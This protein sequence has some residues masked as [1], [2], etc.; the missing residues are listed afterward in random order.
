MVKIYFLNTAGLIDAEL[1][2][3]KSIYKLEKLYH[4]I[5]ASDSKFQPGSTVGSDLQNYEVRR[6][7]T[8]V[9]SIPLFDSRTYKYNDISI[10]QAANQFI[11]FY[12]RYRKPFF[13][14][15]SSYDAIE[16]KINKLPLSKKGSI[17]GYEKQIVLGLL[18]GKYVGRTDFKLLI[19]EYRKYADEWVHFRDP[20]NGALR[21]TVDFLDKKEVSDIFTH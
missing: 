20:F 4:E 3:S 14:H 16:E 11:I 19:N 12:E 13:D 6:K 18:L 2:W 5:V 7:E 9:T 21:K 17:M 15:F 1:F 8:S 10:N